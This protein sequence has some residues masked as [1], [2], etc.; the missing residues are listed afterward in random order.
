MPLPLEAIFFQTIPSPK[1]E[2]VQMAITSHMDKQVVVVPLNPHCP[3]VWRNSMVEINCPD[4]SQECYEESR[5]R[6]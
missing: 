4:E 1:L 5:H 6:T 3:M 2:R